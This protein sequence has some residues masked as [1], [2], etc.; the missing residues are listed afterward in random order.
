MRYIY[1]LFLK[2]GKEVKRYVLKSRIEVCETINNTFNFPLFNQNTFQSFFSRKTLTNEKR[3]EFF[4]RRFPH[5]RL[6]RFNSTTDIP[7]DLEPDFDCVSSF[8]D[9][10]QKQQ[11][12]GYVYKIT[13]HLKNKTVTQLIN[14][15]SNVI[16]WLNNQVGM[17]IFT[18][19][20]FFD[21]LKTDEPQRGFMRYVD[22]EKIYTKDL[23][24]K[25]KEEV[26]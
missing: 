16:K 21:R 7:P 10:T 24:E 1:V 20:M 26:I 12:T 13:I 19:T 25:E 22:I 4:K 6:F 9:N 17:D 2:K 23:S 15:A 11:N 3:Q 5:I 8:Y 14:K 18:I